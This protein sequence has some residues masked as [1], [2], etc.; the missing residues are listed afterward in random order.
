MCG[1]GLSNHGRS[2]TAAA[3]ADAPVKAIPVIPKV[4]NDA[5]PVGLLAGYVNL[6]TSTFL[7]GF[8]KVAGDP[9]DLALAAF[10]VQK[11]KLFLLR[12]SERGSQ[13]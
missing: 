11:G 3:H 10:R 2:G 6:S 4:L 1:T 9:A 13:L 8:K 5:R 12:T 7:R